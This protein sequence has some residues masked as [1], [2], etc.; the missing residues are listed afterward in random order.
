MF[1]A[2]RAWRLLRWHLQSRRSN[3]IIYMH[4]HVAQSLRRRHGS[5]IKAPRVRHGAWLSF[6]R[7]LINLALPAVPSS[8]TRSLQ[9]AEIVPGHV[10]MGRLAS[11]AW[12]RARPRRRLV[13]RECLELAGRRPPVRG[14][15]P[16]RT[17]VLRPG[18]PRA[19]VCRRAGHVAHAHQPRP[20]ARVAPP[21]VQHGGHRSH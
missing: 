8:P 9:D 16:E 4:V 12:L 6:R 20:P 5:R 3:G 17:A 19:L 1:R 18:T 11:R 10:A 2:G 15:A 21:P 7:Y 14:N 13:Y